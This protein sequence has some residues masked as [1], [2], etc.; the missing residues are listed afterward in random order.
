[1]GGPNI[2]IQRCKRVFV[3]V[4]ALL[5]NYQVTE[6]IDYNMNVG[7]VVRRRVD[8]SSCIHRNSVVERRSMF[9]KWLCRTRLDFHI[10]VFIALTFN[11]IMYRNRESLCKIRNIVILRERT[12]SD[13]DTC[14]RVFTKFIKDCSIHSGRKTDSDSIAYDIWRRGMIC[15]RRI[16][17][18]CV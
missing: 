11:A 5:C 12:I 18:R 3:A 1:M 13:F 6:S 14:M 16:C 17:I 7:C 2:S 4:L 15:C 9:C 8:R 10:K